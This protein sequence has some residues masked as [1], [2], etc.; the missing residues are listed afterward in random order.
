[1][2]T[3]PYKQPYLEMFEEMKN[4]IIFQDFSVE[5]ISTFLESTS[6]RLFRDSK[7]CESGNTEIRRAAL[8][9]REGLI[10]FCL[11]FKVTDCLSTCLSA[12]L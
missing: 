8:A 4:G 10:H 11:V 7:D 6:D 9:V 1:M 2:E 12:N 3:I 5:A